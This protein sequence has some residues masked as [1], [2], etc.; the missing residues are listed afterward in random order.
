MDR[1]DCRMP[2]RPWNSM[3]ALTLLLGACSMQ[4][5]PDAESD[6]APDGS[7]RD[8]VAECTHV[9]DVLQRRK[10]LDTVERD[11]EQDRARRR[12]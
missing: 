8:R 7:W 10:C 3:S 5:L 4:P 2:R 1:K 11:R 6:A 12:N 9:G